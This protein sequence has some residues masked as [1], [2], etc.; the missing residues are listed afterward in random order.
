V[1]I[2]I[3]PGLSIELKNAITALGGHLVFD[4]KEDAKDAIRMLNPDYADAH[5]ITD[6]TN[7]TD[8]DIV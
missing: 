8:F 1:Y 5:V 6:L 2:I 4:S 3:P 7:V